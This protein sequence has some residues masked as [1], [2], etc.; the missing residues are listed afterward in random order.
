[1]KYNSQDLKRVNVYDFEYG[2]DTNKQ[3]EIWFT[4]Q[5]NYTN[6][7]WLLKK[8]FAPK[9][10]QK[11]ARNTINLPNEDDIWPNIKDTFPVVWRST[12]HENGRLKMSVW[13]AEPRTEVKFMPPYIQ[14]LN[15]WIKDFD[16]LATGSETPALIISGDE[17]IGILMP[18]R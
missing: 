1:M 9:N 2:F 7:Q 12:D 17:I 15:R 14:F 18:T 11:R 16:L 10:V 3:K 5:G 6:G 13:I 4:K 8:E